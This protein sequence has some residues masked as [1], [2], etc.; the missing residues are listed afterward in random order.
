MKVLEELFE[1][2]SMETKAE[3]ATLR[4]VLTPCRESAV[5]K[6][7]FPDK[8]ITP[9]VLMIQGVVELLE[10]AQRER[11]TLREVKNIKYLALM[12][13]DDI[14]GCTVEATLKDDGSASA[15]YAK[16]DTVFAK[17]K[18]ALNTEH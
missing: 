14:E 5:Y 11:Y 1:V 8:P 6:G 12:T 4:A 15:T 16:G 18:L 10:R 9:G 2:V 7:H 17:M 13:P 3:G